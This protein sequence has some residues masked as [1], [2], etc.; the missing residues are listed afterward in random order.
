MQGTRE[1]QDIHY[2]S[3][4]VLV[5]MLALWDFELTWIKEKYLWMQPGQS[6]V[7]KI[8]ALSLI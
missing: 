8:E 4:E 3:P 6:E 5:K 7:S 2:C 1:K